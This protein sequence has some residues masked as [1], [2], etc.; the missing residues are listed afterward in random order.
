MRTQQTAVRQI[1]NEES[2]FRWFDVL[3]WID[4]CAGTIIDKE[5]LAS[6]YNCDRNAYLWE[7]SFDRS[8][9]VIMEKKL[10]DKEI[11]YNKCGW[12]LTED[13]KKFS[14]NLLLVH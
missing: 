1:E 9:L 6:S 11:L 14:S 2:M 7:S 8:I 3:A 5:T 12:R 13:T 4:R 10:N